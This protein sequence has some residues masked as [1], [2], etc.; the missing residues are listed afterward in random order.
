MVSVLVFSRTAGYRHEAIPAGI[1]AIRS[2]GAADGFA[3]A[4]TEDTVSAAAVKKRRRRYQAGGL[5]AMADG[6]EVR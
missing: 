4:A 6:R 5:A 1:A 3:V 2:L